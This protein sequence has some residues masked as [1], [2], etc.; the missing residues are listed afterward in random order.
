MVDVLWIGKRGGST[1][2]RACS[3]AVADGLRELAG[4]YGLGSL[5]LEAL[6]LTT[7]LLD[8]VVGG[9][10]AL[11]GALAFLGGGRRHDG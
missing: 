4:V 10:G 8:A 6:V 2:S 3:G 9:A 5:A 7:K 1:S 11:R